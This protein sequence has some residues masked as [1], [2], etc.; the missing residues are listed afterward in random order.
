MASLSLPACSHLLNARATSTL[1]MSSYSLKTQRKYRAAVLSFFRW[2]LSNYP[3]DPPSRSNI[4]MYLSDYMGHLHSNGHG[5]AEASCCLSGLDMFFPGI[6]SSLHSSKRAL[7]GYM[8]LFPS[9]S[10][11]PLPWPVCVVIAAWLAFND[12]YSMGL[13]VLISFDGY[14]RKEEVLQLRYEDIAI[15]SDPRLGVISDGVDG[16][17]LADDRVHIH[18]RNAKTGRFQGIEIR[19]PHVRLLVREYRQQHHHGQR[20]FTFSGSS[21]HRWFKRACF[22]L[23]LTSDYSLHCLRHGG[24][25]RDYLDGVPINDVMLRGRWV[26]IKSATRYIQTGRQLMMLNSVSP[27]IDKIGRVILPSLYQFMLAVRR[28]IQQHH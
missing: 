4:D 20:L 12:R 28:I 26:G 13:A 5:K 17:S 19:D 6:T 27:V 24:A 22:N 1:I 2:W 7:K 18:I 25:T 10:K 14:L 15:G 23:D 21:Y 16:K 9:V 8:R 11:P 3:S